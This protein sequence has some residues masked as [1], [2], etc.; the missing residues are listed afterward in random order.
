MLVGL[1][2]VTMP[3]GP[4]EG[5]ATAMRAAADDAKEMYGAMGFA[6]GEI[7]LAFDAS[8]RVV[9]WVLPSVV[10]AYVII[11]LFWIRPRIPLL[12][13]DVEVAPF[14]EYRGDEWLAAV[15]AAVGSWSA[16]S[17]WVA[18]DGSRSTC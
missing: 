3:A 7:E 18:R 11:V 10:I 13:Y 6:E 17:R 12:G 4:V 16:L 5:V 14:E 2:V 1:A 8:E 9:P 15:F